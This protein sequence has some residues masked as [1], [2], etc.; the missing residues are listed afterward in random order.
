MTSKR[1]PPWRI[2]NRAFTVSMEGFTPV[3]N[4][5]IGPQ[6]PKDF[7]WELQAVVENDDGSWDVITPTE[8]QHWAPMTDEEYGP[9][10]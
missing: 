10:T 8:P 1:V 5:Y 3:V 2:E 6:A 9:V 4:A 7:E